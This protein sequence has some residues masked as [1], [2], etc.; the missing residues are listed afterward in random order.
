MIDDLLDD[1]GIAY[2]EDT[3]E[4]ELDDDFDDDSDDDEFDVG[5]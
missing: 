1:D 4:G 2:P 5:D 3:D